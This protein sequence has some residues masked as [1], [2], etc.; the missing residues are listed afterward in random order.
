MVVL[1]CEIF[2]SEIVCISLLCLCKSLW[3][4]MFEKWIRNGN[5]SLGSDASAFKFVV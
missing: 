5:A 1:K 2:F 3:K 4:T